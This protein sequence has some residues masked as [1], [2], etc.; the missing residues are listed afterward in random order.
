MK[1]FFNSHFPI[2]QVTEPSIL[3]NQNPHDYGPLATLT[4]EVAGN[5]YRTSFSGGQYGAGVIVNDPG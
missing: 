4:M 5:L 1:D 3:L 2:S